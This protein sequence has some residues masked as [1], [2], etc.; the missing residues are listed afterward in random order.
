MHPIIDASNPPESG[1]IQSNERLFALNVSISESF[2]RKLVQAHQQIRLPDGS[3]IDLRSILELG[4]ESLLNQPSGRESSI[5]QASD[6]LEDDEPTT[7]R[8]P[9][10]MRWHPARKG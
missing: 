2:Y 8:A 3:R 1:T 4:L 10:T 9:L 7:V 6:M 5:S